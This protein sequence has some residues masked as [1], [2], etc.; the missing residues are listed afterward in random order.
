MQPRLRLQ[1]NPDLVT[2]VAFYAF[3]IVSVFWSSLS[4]AAIMKSAALAM[5][6]FGAFSPRHA[7]RP[8]RNRE[9][10]GPWASHIGRRVGCLCGSRARHRDRPQLDAQRSMV[11]R[12]RIE[13]N[14]RLRRRV[15]DVLGQLSKDDGAG[16]AGLPRRFPA[17][18][19]L[20]LRVGI[21][22]R[23]RCRSGRLRH[24]R[25]LDVVGRLHEA[26]C[27]PAVHHV[28]LAGLLILD[29]YA[30]G[31]DAI[32][33]GD[34]SIDFTERTFIWHYA[35][36]HFNDAPLLGFGINGFWTI[37]SIYDYFEQNHGWCRQLS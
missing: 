5:T 15:S 14:A 32:H 23:R 37:P 25:D 4:V 24:A 8:G 9:S 1:V 10:H 21:A 28:V 2:L 18:V 33:I 17:G 34:A 36:S 3:A 31:Y 19:N 20:C 16:V 27:A 13:A 26:L 7:R 11:G 30:T 6:T 35:I 22:R 12:L 29:F